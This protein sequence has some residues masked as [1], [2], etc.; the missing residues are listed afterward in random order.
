MAKKFRTTTLSVLIAFI[1]LAVTVSTAFAAPP[2]GVH[3]EVDEF[4]GTSGETFFVSGSAVA[5]GTVCSTGT[6]DDVSI[7]TSGLQAVHLRFSMY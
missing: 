4:V 2:L 5:A 6:V 3:I 7:E 1:L